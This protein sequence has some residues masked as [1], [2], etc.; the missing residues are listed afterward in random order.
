MYNSLFLLLLRSS[1]ATFHV[2]LI[3]SS[4]RLRACIGLELEPLVCCIPCSSDHLVNSSFS[5]S[6]R[7][8]NCFFL[9]ADWDFS[10]ENR[11]NACFCDWYL[12]R[13]LSNHYD[14]S[15]W[16]RRWLAKIFWFLTVTCSVVQ[17]FL[18]LAFLWK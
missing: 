12:S 10:Q 4:R 17:Y 11:T 6:H 13:R 3:C 5:V 8:R 2:K 18:W 1:L 15:A 7:T 9:L 16:K 14:S